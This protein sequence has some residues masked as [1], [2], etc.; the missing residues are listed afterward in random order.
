VDII[1][2]KK[3]YQK[4]KHIYSEIVAA[5]FDRN[6]ALCWRMNIQNILKIPHEQKKLE[7]SAKFLSFLRQ[8]TLS[9]YE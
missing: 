4:L 7:H 1:G 6:T 2:I 9:W 5:I 8:A 3:T